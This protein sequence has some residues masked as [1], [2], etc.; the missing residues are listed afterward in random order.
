MSVV[1]ASD[2]ILL[3]YI[4]R[5]KNVYYDYQNVYYGCF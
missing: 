4:V 5:F 3:V 2:S 1:S